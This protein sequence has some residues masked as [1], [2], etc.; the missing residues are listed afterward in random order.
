MA[1][2][3]SKVTADEINAASFADP[4]FLHAAH[5]LARKTPQYSY[6]Y[7]GHLVYDSAPFAL[8]CSIRG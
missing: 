4:I 7:N 3:T 2:P 6:F 8:L 5:P 1:K